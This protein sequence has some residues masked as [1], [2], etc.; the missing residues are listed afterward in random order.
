MESNALSCS[1]KE[2]FKEFPELDPEADDF[3]N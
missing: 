2:F 1:V 3:Q